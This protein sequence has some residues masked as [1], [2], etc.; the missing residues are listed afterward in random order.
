MVEQQK[1]IKRRDEQILNS[2]SEKKPKTSEDL[3]KEKLILEGAE[4]YE[5]Y[6][7]YTIKIMIDKHFEKLYKQKLIEPVGEG[8]ILS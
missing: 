3:W 1:Y 5:K 2:L 6:L 4:D 7:A 8:Y